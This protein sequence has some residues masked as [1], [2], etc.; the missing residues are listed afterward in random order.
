MT[1]FP[2]LTPAVEQGI[3]EAYDFYEAEVHPGILERLSDFGTLRTG[4]PN[5]VHDCVAV[6]LNK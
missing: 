5:Q 2:D 4:I 3:N 6:A 1:N